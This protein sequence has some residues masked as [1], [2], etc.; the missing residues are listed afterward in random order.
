MVFSALL[1]AC[2]RGGHGT[3]RKPLRNERLESRHEV[4]VTVALCGVL[5]PEIGAEEAE[6]PMR[7]IQPYPRLHRY[8]LDE[9]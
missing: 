3:T 4:V 7:H 8:Q 2:A 9:E 6:V 5:G 1:K